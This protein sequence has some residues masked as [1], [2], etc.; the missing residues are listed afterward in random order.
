MPA[1]GTFRRHELPSDPGAI[2]HRQREPARPSSR[3]PDRDVDASLALRAGCHWAWPDSRV[4]PA[5]DRDPPAARLA[6]RLPRRA[7]PHP[8]LAH[9]GRRDQRTWSDSSGAQQRRHRD[10]DLTRA[11]RRRRTGSHHRAGQQHP[12][13]KRPAVRQGVDGVRESEGVRPPEPTATSHASRSCRRDT[14]LYRE[15]LA[16]RARDSAA[17]LRR[18]PARR[19]RERGGHRGAQKGEYA[20]IQAA[21]GGPDDQEVHRTDS[22]LEAHDAARPAARRVATGMHPPVAAESG[23]RAREGDT[24]FSR[25]RDLSLGAHTGRREINDPASNRPRQHLPGDRHGGPAKRL[26]AVHQRGPRPR[27]DTRSTGTRSASIG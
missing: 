12:D 16:L 3:Q 26:L 18:R 22:R 27:H 9:L 4:P 1:P 19:L 2:P 15:A 23:E 25:R 20:R 17:R 14:A 11:R 6:R 10:G 13:G 7:H 24:P 5:S 21:G 8:S